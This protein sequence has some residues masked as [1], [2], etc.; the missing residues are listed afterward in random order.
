M[1]S[2]DWLQARGQPQDHADREVALSRFKRAFTSGSPDCMG[3]ERGC[4]PDA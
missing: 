4:D 2:A 3:Q 1:V